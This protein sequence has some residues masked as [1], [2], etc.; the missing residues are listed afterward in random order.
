[1]AFELAKLPY[2][3]SPSFPGA[4]GQKVKEESWDAMICPA[5]P[6]HILGQEINAKFKGQ[7]VWSSGSL[8]T[9]EGGQD[10]LPVDTW[11]RHGKWVQTERGWCVSGTQPRPATEYSLSWLFR[12]SIDVD[13][14]LTDILRPIFNQFR[15]Y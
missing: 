9:A 13:Q 15:P 12:K 6:L 5:H 14:S 11:T 2:H 1:M 3:F 10:Y 7:P 4:I 8:R